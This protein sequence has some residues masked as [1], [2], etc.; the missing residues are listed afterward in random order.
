MHEAAS[1][2]RDALLAFGHRVR[3][4][5]ASELGGPHRF[6]AQ[7][8]ERY[9]AAAVLALFAPTDRRS[10]VTDAVRDAADIFFVQRSP[11]LR[12][13]PGQISL[14]G[15]TIEPGES[16][17]QAAVRETHEEIGL[18]PEHVDVITDLAPVSVPISGFVVTPVLAWTDTPEAAAEVATGEVLHTLR[19]RV[20]HLLDPQHR[21]TVTIA[22]HRS[23]G[24][25]VSAGWIW[26]FTG[27]LM[28]HL[29]D[30]L[31]WTRPWNRERT[32]AMTMAQARGDH[33]RRS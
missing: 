24:F 23:S 15:G 32:H 11:E 9:R 28:D 25:E 33:L 30:E 10:R 2:T 4:G 21:A 14:P 27:N 1:H 3:R 16:P 8:A 12:H 22:G 7:D 20:A 31:G 6:D 19:V 13:H 29:L 17:V 5:E 26:G 18:A